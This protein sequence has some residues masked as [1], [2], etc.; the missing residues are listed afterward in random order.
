[1]LQKSGPR[2]KSGVTKK[3]WRFAPEAAEN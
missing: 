2:I 1:M 3:E